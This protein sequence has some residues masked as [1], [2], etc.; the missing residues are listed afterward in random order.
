MVEERR[1]KRVRRR[2]PLGEGQR[3]VFVYSGAFEY[4][5]DV[6]K[7]RSTAVGGAVGAVVEGYEVLDGGRVFVCLEL[8][9]HLARTTR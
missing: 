1:V 5:C 6:V 7:R 8:V 3:G 9:R 4:P 2:V